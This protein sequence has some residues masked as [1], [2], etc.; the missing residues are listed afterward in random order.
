MG[1][2][3]AHKCFQNAEY[4]VSSGEGSRRDVD[5]CTAAIRNGRLSRGDLVTTHLNRGI[6]KAKLGDISGAQEDY[7]KALDL[8]DQSPEIFLNLG[9]LQF[10]M[11]DFTSA[12]A[13]YD[14]AES[15]GG[16]ERNT[17]ILY[18]N[19]GMALVRLGR[20]DDAEAEY[21]V[22]FEQ[23]PGWGNAL[24]QLELRERIREGLA[25]ESQT[26]N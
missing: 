20:L 15:L 2:S 21:R 26:G 17:H 24:D 3:V 9:N 23:R 1:A 11:Q 6:I 22:A 18:L 13:D 10:L 8:S 14:Q 7:L 5:N 25:E 19:R 4:A 12:I 16:L